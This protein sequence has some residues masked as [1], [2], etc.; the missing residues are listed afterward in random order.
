MPR[1]NKNTKSKL[2]QFR[3]ATFP[4]LAI[5]VAVL[6]GLVGVVTYL[7]SNALKD[8]TQVV[9]L[10]LTPSSARITRG[11][12]IA[13]NVMVNT[14]NQPVN[15]VQA[16]LSYPADYLEFVAIDATNSAF[17]IEA[18]AIGGNGSVQIARGNFQPIT[19]AAQ[20]ATVHFR[21]KLPTR[22]A[23]VSFSSGSEII[24]A[25]SFQNILIKTVG[26]KY[27]IR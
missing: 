1:K 3:W 21:A 19:G 26:A 15:A 16:N 22:S 4:G 14:L 10:Y 13:V 8:S 23:P 5:V 18:Q 25:T 2:K 17:S 12:T 11:N 24:H 6:F 7:Q 9:S 27:T 20:L